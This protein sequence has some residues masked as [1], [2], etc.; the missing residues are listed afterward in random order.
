MRSKLC[1]YQVS[2]SHTITEQVGVS[3]L[4]LMP[5]V[6]LTNVWESAP[7]HGLSIRGIDLLFLL[8]WWVW[9]QHIFLYRKVRRGI[10]LF[11][12][13]V[14]SAFLISLFG[15]IVLP[16]YQVNWPP[17]LR[18]VQTLLWGGL[19][20]SFVRNERDLKAIARSVIAAGALLGS[21]SFYLYLTEHGLQRIAGYFSAAGGAGLGRQASFN[22]I[23]A[24]YALAAVLALNY[25]FWGN[26]GSQ[27]WESIAIITGFLLNVLGLVLVQSRSAF[28]AFFI[29]SSALFLRG[30]NLRRLLTAGRINKKAI[31]FS[32]TILAIAAF[33]LISTA[34]LVAVDRISRTFVSGSSEYISASTRLILWHGGIRVWLD[35]APY[36]LLG[37]GFRST[38]R[39]IGAESAHNFFLNIGLWLGVAGLV[40]VLIL[41]IWPVLKRRA[42][43]QE[44]AGVAVAAA[45]VALTVSMFGNTLVDPFYGGCTFLILYGSLAASFPSREGSK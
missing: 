40:P 29:G 9:A 28:L 26:K 33:I 2:A 34:H 12:G 37:Y 19:A 23:G 22:E 38:G 35:K 15:L 39:F 4:I 17:L 24:L 21:Y 42:G 30:L 32:T 16:K 11:L 13:L 27:R 36:F 43:G 41:L 44:I 20:L 5:L 18:F 8:T 25:L 6:S 1:V 14:S 10:I 45:A 3:L 7:F 31:I